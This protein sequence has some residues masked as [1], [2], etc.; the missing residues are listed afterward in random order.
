MTETWNFINT[1][2]KDPYYNMAMD[3]A[4]L[5]F[6]S[7]GEV[8]PDI[9]FYTWNPARLSIGYFHRLLTV[10]DI[11]K[12]NETVFGFVMRQVVGLVVLHDKQLTYSVIVPESQPN[13]PSTVTEVYRVISQRLLYVFTNLVFDTYIAV[14]NT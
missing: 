11:D 6:V 13:M 3:E 1:G 7:R 2:S 5:N 14:P 10:I 8:D 12:V 4:L 9:R